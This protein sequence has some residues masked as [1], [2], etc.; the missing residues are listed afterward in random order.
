MTGRIRTYEGKEY[1][2]P[3]PLAWKFEY[4]CGVPC[5]SFWLELPWQEGEEE[6]YRKAVRF[7]AEEAGEPVF[8]GVID[9]AEWTR[10]RRGS[11][12]V[13]AGRS[14]AALLLDNEAEAADYGTATLADILA[15]HVEPYGI[16]C[17]QGEGI[18]PCQNF[19]VAGGSSCWQ[20]VY[21]FVRYHGSI[22]PRFDLRGRLVLTPFED[23]IIKVLDDTV[24]VTSFA[25]REKRYG[26]LSEIVVRDKKR[27]T[28]ERVVNEEFS[29]Q[30]GQARRILTMTGAS[31]QRAM[32]YNGQF[33]LEKSESGRR[34]LELTVP[35]LFFAWPGQLI[36]MARTDCGDNGV[37][38]V[39]ESAVIQDADGGRTGLVLGLPDATV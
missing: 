25:G 23:Q 12:V 30:G 7:T 28:E 20:V 5:D 26:V 10:D 37:W 14:L 24:P 31:G 17:V 8:T 29:G 3:A 15:R 39:L 9:E 6:T 34:R 19:S 27:K 22:P 2:L 32:R 11:R 13:L 36:S 1:L 33:Q 4:A 16:E 21:D 38:R 35:A 18:P